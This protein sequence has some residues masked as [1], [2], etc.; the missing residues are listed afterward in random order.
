[1]VA[2]RERTY[3]GSILLVTFGGMTAAIIAVITLAQG[4]AIYIL[5]VT[6]DPWRDTPSRLPHVAHQ[7][8]LPHDAHVLSGEVDAVLTELEA[9]D[10]AIGRDS[11]TGEVTHPALVY[12]LDRE[13]RIAFATTGGG[14]HAAALVRRLTG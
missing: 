1:M 5:V 11:L 12:V 2:K 14:E 13:G 3:E 9:W 6:V 10:V 7:W 4:A 8:D